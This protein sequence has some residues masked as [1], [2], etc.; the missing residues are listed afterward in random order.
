MADRSAPTHGRRVDRG[1]TLIETVIVV[2]II[3]IVSGTMVGVV[4][5]VLRTTPPTEVRSD[6][7]RSLQ[8]LVTW[9][10]QDVDAAPPG[11]F[12]TDPSVASWPCGGSAPAAPNVNLL[13][14]EWVERTD[15]TAHFAAAYWYELDVNEW[16]IARYSCDDGGT[17]TMGS[18]ERQNLTSELPPWDDLARPAFVVMCDQM[19]QTLG[20]CAAGHEITTY[21]SPSV[22]SLKMTVTRLDGAQSTID[23]APKNPDQDLAD[24]PLAVLNQS[25]KVDQTGYVYEMFAGDT[26]VLD[27]TVDTLHHPVD[28]DGDPISVAIDTSE[29]FPAGITAATIDP[30]S[31]EI[32]TDPGLSP[33]NLDK[34][35]L[36]ISDNRAGWVGATI[37]VKIKPE[38][39]LAPTATAT[40]YAL[41]L[42]ASDV[43]TIPL[44]V[45]HGLT[46][47]NGDPLTLTPVG[48]PVELVFAPTTGSPL[49]PFEVQITAPPV[50][51]AGPATAPIEIDARDPFGEHI[52]VFIDITWVTPTPPNQAPTI[53]QYDVPVTMSPGDTLSYSLDTSHGLT[54]PDGHPLT[55][56]VTS[57]PAG[58][59]TP[60]LTGGLGVDIE[61][62]LGLSPGTYAPIDLVAEDIHGATVALRFTV[63]IVPTPAP[64]S[65]CV[66]GTLT[67][68]PNPVGRQGNGAGARFL[69]QDVTVTVTYTGSCDGLVLNYDSGDT[70]GLGVG[71]G[72]VFPIG[73][74]ASITIYAHGNGGTE[75]WTAGSHVLTASTTSAVTPNSITTTLTVS[76]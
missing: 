69:D 8:G 66:L 41:T 59:I 27:L 44:D 13:T 17:G 9:L 55:L 39:N 2:L 48:W 74:P 43:V 23:A 37:T 6:D 31:I 15:V 28:P 71:T 42:G 20:S 52:D 45:T 57:Y 65:D 68:S 63:T 32:T 54:D 29:P 16:H 46:D 64:A 24:D 58:A 51:V 47:P 10:P 72:R 76:S 25:P 75:K 36:V 33:G 18:P 61:A 40:H 49:G 21:T 11:G 56:A 50:V 30:M 22:E 14:I 7:A 19:D 73:S 5:V 4:A 1:F 67:A 26:V 60:V 53:T 35:F 12:N 34:L 38:P 70:S 3:G 62:D